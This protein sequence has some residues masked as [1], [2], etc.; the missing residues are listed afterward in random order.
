M[1][2]NAIISSLSKR[3]VLMSKLGI[4][5][6]GRFTRIALPLIALCWAASASASTVIDGVAVADPGDGVTPGFGS[7]GSGPSLTNAIEYFIPLSEAAKG[8]YGVGTLCGGDGAGTC[9]DD[10]SG[11]GYGDPTPD[12]DILPEALFMNIFFKMDGLPASKSAE[13]S[14]EFDDLD[15]K[16]V[17]DP[18]G[19][20]ESISLSYW[21]WDSSTSTFDTLESLSGTIHEAIT[22]PPPDD[23]PLKTADDNLITWDLSLLAL[24]A[25]NTSAADKQGFWIQLG[26][27]SSYTGTGRNTPEYLTA[28]LTV[29]PVP[30][31]AAVWLFGTTLIGFVGMSRRTKIS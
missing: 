23:A 31:P 12:P 11:Y 29:S 1:P 5:S 6:R 28:E 24:D 4:K 16:D 18:T 30:V 3:S 13:L 25:L 8:T 19:F 14:F 17:N 27:G 10:G 26:F 15:L 22:T 20:F 21:N 9:A 2:Q 7:I